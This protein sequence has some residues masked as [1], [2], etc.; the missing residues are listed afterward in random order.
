MRA[1]FALLIAATTLLANE[2]TNSDIS[3]LATT[4]VMHCIYRNWRDPFE[5]QSQLMTTIV[6]NEH[7]R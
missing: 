5:L 2:E 6:K 4:D 7:G 1:Y 3:Q